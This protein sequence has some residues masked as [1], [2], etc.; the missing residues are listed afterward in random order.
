MLDVALWIACPLFVWWFST[1]LV[2]YLDGL[3]VHTY[4]RSA[5]AS[6]VVLVAALYGFVRVSAD[7]T[8]LGVCLAFGY[9]I[10]IWG[11]LELTYL[12]GLLSGPRSEPCPP[13]CSLGERFRL[14]LQTSIY[15]ELAVVVTGIMLLAIVQGQPNAFGAWA[16]LVLW[17]MRWSTKLNIFF[18]VPNL[19]E[20]FWP[21]H[22]KYLSSYCGHRP[23]NALF[24]FSVTAA[25]VV[26]VLLGMEA[27][28]AASAFEQ[29]GY[30]IL[31]TLL[32]LAVIEHWFLVLPIREAA[33]WQWA[34]NR[35]RRA[36]AMDLDLPGGPHA[37]I[38]PPVSGH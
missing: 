3:P 30:T 25:T 28:A 35:Q 23:M 4:R 2:L 29:A 18:G 1:G 7:A 36:E 31:A 37:A 13:G 33:L 26:V 9:A 21:D 15:H 6:T 22:M 17:L 20:E 34:L 24:P 8:P 11:W 10:I 12:M 27:A 38:S 16:F 32:A 5:A 14:A 19:A